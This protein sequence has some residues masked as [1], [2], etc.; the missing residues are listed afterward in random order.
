MTEI[1]H[2]AT[3]A[4]FLSAVPVLLGFRP[5]NSIVCVAFRGRRTAELLRL[6][7]PRQRRS[8]QKAVASTIVGMLSRITGISGASMIIYTDETFEG[9]HGIP[10]LELGRMLSARI[11]GAGFHLPNALCVAGDGWADYFDT[12]YPRQG[13]PLSMITDSEVAS[14]LSGHEV[15]NDLDDVAALPERDPLIAE[16][17]EFLLDGFERH[18]DEAMLELNRLTKLMDVDPASCSCSIAENPTPP[19]EVSAW[20]LSMAQRPSDRDVMSITI[21]FGCEFGEAILQSNAQYHL[22]QA[23]SGSTMDEVVQREVDAG[24]IDLDDSNNLLGGKGSRRPNVPRVKGCIELL[25][26]LIAN[27]PDHY[28]PGPLCMLSWLQWSLGRGS[29]A[30]TASDMALAIDPNHSMALLLNTMLDA[31]MLPEWVYGGGDAAASA[32]RPDPAACRVR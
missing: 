20:M 2:A 29:A 25:K 31:G 4:D 19:L 26:E 28:R 7:L 22:L 23:E 17:L 21:A 24:R 16:R 5:R 14:Q 3:A 6:D 11:H 10:Q 18:T 32:A 9:E 27:I 12:G 15:L 8:N 30:G 1:L 13:H